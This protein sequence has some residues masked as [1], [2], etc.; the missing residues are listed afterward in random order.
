MNLDVNF[1]NNR[2]M[3]VGDYKIAMLCFKDVIFRYPFHAFAHYYLAK[4]QE[5]MNEDPEKIKLN[6]DKFNEI[7]KRDTV[8]KEYAEYFNLNLV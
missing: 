1:V 5:A 8:W 7:I 6:M 2:R 3:R 4:A